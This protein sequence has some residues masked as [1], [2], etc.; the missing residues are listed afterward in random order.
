MNPLRWSRP[1][2]IALLLAAAVG[3][4]L[5]PL[6][7]YGIYAV[8]SG[9]AGAMSFGFWFDPAWRPGVLLWPLFGSAISAAIVYISH[10]HGLD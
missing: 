9:A 3:V 1:H 5:G 6:I 10:L 4:A 7:G 2:Q 8:G